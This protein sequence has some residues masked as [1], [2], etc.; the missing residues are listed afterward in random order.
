VARR[1]A[2]PHAAVLATIWKDAAEALGAEA[3]ELEGGVLEIRRDAAHARVWHHVTP[4]DDP[5]TVRVALERPLVHRLLREADVPV[6][7]HVEAAAGRPGNVLAFVHDRSGPFVVKPASGTSGGHGVTGSVYGSAQALRACLAAARFDRRLLV[8]E[9]TEGEMYR[10]L[11]L[12]GELLGAVRRRA[13]RVTGDGRST[14]A[15]LI[16]EENRRRL[17]A[18]GSAGLALLR[19]DLDCVLTL[20][21]QGLSLRSVLPAGATVVAKVASSENSPADNDVVQERPAEA[22]VQDARA[23]AA[24]VGLR[25]AGVDVVTSD[26]FRDLDDTGGA[27]I[28]VNGTPGLHYHYQVANPDGAIPVAVPILRRLLDEA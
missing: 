12:D 6:P 11:L 9:Q 18:N 16:A 28:E 27:V 14:V 1:F 20:R 10:L 23:A 5:V 15:G 7:D 3:I 26:P 4:F 13:P 21:A 17:A 22:L 19:P 25:L 2:P 8:E 24:A